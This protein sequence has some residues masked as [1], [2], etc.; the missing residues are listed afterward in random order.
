[1]TPDD[2]SKTIEPSDNEPVAPE[3]N[4]ML[5]SP[6]FYL[7][8][9]L[10]W[11]A[12]NERVLHEAEDERTPLLERLKF[13]SI[14]SANIDEFF[15]KRIGGLKV[16]ASAGLHNNRTVDGRTPVEQIAECYRNIRALE[17]RKRELLSDLKPVLR[18]KGIAL[19]G[20][21]DLAAA[22]QESLRQHYI[23]NIFPLVTPQAMD[24]AHPFPFVSNLSL[25]L[26]VG[27]HY[28]DD[29]TPLLARLKVPITAGIPRFQRVGDSL[30]FVPLEEVVANNLDLLFPGMVIDTCD[31]F[32]VTRNAITEKDEEQAEDLLALI[33]T[34]LQER[35]FAPIV[36]LQVHKNM[37][38]HN[39]TKLAA[40]LGLNEDS[41]VFE[42][43]SLMGMRDL[44]EIARLDIAAL[45]DSPHFPVDHP[46]FVD[47][48]SI[49]DIIRRA[50]VLVYHPYQSF[51]SSVERF[52]G[53]AS[54]DPKVRAIKMTL[55]RTSEESRVVDHLIEAAQNGKQVVVVVEIKAR[56]DE[57]ANIHWANRLVEAGIHVT[58]GVVGLKTHCKTILVVRQDADGLRR[59]A[60]L[61]TGNYHAGTARLYADLGLFTAEESIA[62]DLTELFNY[63]TT[64]YRPKRKYQ[65]LLPAP[66]LL[67][68]ALLGKIKREIEKHTSESPG[69]IQIKTN[70]LEDYD[71]TRALYQA[72]QAG[73]QVD[74][75]VRDS[76][77]V[78]P[79]VPGLSDNIRVVS[80]V[81]RFLEHARI[82]YFKNAGKEEYFIGS[83]DMMQRNLESRVESVVPVTS[84][85]LHARLRHILDTQLADR[86]SAWDMQQ[87]GTYVQRRSQDF[88]AKS[89]HQ[90]FIE[91]AEKEHRE[92]TRLRK[93]KPKGVARR[94]IP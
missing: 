83:A 21:R 57:G 86:R 2:T 46:A 31:T 88:K 93:R 45:R 14:V 28:A 84:P 9:E 87:D 62:A 17:H 41:D 39:R 64:G 11:L 25:N 27:L 10:T 63:L 79:Q 73:V 8:R 60:H 43:E 85:E 65:R 90:Q 30:T 13:I 54:T 34:E 12:F 58:Y 92:A 36:R 1:M 7:N 23:K 38:E 67:K 40:E 44:A 74:L 77:R 3:A 4:A 6:E 47:D 53:E 33:E 68:A 16:Q 69:L 35:R 26:L 82:F 32:R 19:V 72:S 50:P 78:R 51:A 56:F 89:C 75:I 5:D 61:G 76:C 66:K 24:P 81:G 42:L 49:F 52:L 48:A 37:S 70:A 59:Y 94:L 22:E 15:M 80:V 91:D 20:Y 29:P 71:I 55:Y 18:A